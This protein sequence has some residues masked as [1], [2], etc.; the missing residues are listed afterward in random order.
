MGILLGARADIQLTEDRGAIGRSTDR[1][2]VYPTVGR[3]R[4]P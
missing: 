2:V 3:H 1:F 4:V